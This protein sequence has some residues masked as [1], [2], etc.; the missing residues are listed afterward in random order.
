MVTMTF[1]A[2]LESEAIVSETSATAGTHSSLDYLPGACFLGACAAKLYDN[3]SLDEAFTVFHSGKVRFGNAYP[4]SPNGI[5]AL[6]VPAAWHFFKG[7]SPVEEGKI[8]VAGIKNLLHTSAETFRDWESSGRQPKQMREGYSTQCGDFIPKSSGYRLKTAI[9]RSTKRAAE[10]QLFGYESLDAG[11]RWWF[12]VECDDDVSRKICTDI[13]EALHNRLRVGR[14]RTA[15]NG[16]VQ[17]SLEEKLSFAPAVSEE[18]SQHIHLYCVSD[19]ALREAVSGSPVNSPAAAHFQLPDG[20][21]TVADRSFIRIRRYA[22]FNG[23]RKANDLERQVISKG[24]VITFEKTDGSPFT[25]VELK[26]LRNKLACGVGMYRHDGLGKVLVNPSFIMTETVALQETVQFAQ[27]P[28]QPAELANTNQELITWMIGRSSARTCEVEISAQVE[29]WAN[30]LVKKICALQRTLSQ[31]PGKSQWGAVREIASSPQTTRKVL[32]DKL[33]GENT[34]LCVHGVSM[35]QWGEEFKYEND[36]VSFA[37][38]L[39]TIVL[40]KYNNDEQAR[41]ALYL[42]AERI[43]KKMN[44]HKE[45]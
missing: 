16:I 14:S 1:V 10:A 30:L 13:A 36:W 34:G 23:K 43:P 11:S 42:L 44:Q 4:L 40:T 5:P 7:E 19:L 24:S 2:T 27:L 20:V 33:F 22:P 3:L 17:V 32:N 35:I 15:E 39:R 26:D 18:A 25:G 6:P 21:R 28:E 9:D 12:T 41:K 29:I 31:F 38:F 45:G 8:N 37:E